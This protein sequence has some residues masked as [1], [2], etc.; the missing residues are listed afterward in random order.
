MIAGVILLSLGLKKV[1]G[2]V[3]GEDDHV[4]SDPLY[5]LPLVA[6]Y[7]GAALYLLAHAAFIMRLLGV[8]AVT[9][10]LVAA[11]LLAAIPIAAN[12]PALAALAGL[13]LAVAAGVG[14]ESWRHA[15]YRDE[16]RHHDED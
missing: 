4:L 1:L 6:L 13:A 10:L 12:V 3:G 7:G 15:D 9:R 14:Y 8:L 5:G 2:Y 16:V 11:L